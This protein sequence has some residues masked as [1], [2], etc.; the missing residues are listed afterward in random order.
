MTLEPW[1][2]KYVQ[3]LRG[4]RRSPCTRTNNKNMHQQE[5]RDGET[6]IGSE[7]QI[8]A[9]DGGTLTAYLALPATTP[10]PGLVVLP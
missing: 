9:A 4:V 6:M 7:I 2:G 3:A 5:Q 10:A 8:R 1:F